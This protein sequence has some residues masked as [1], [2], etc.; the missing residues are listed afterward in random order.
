MNKIFTK[1]LLGIFTIFLFS[2]TS[3]AATSIKLEQPQTQTYKND[4]GLTFV[5]LDTNPS[6]LV[7]VQCQKKGP[8]DA[9]FVNFG[10]LIVLS[11]GGNTDV[12]QVNSGIVNQNEFIYQFRAIAN[13]STSNVLSNSVSVKF[14]DQ[15]PGAPEGY[16]KTMSDSCTYKISFKT[17]NDS[18]TVRVVLYRSTETIFTVDLGHQVNALN[19][20][21]NTE[22]SILDNITPN[23]NTTYYYVIRAYDTYGKG[24]DLRGDS[25]VTTTVVNPTATQVQGAILVTTSEEEVLGSTESAEPSISPEVINTNVPNWILTHKKI[26]LLGLIIIVCVYLFFNRK[27]HKKAKRKK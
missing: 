21:P 3:F 25:N 24:S 12:C 13:G 5:A 8:S 17:A 26:S 4:F 10:S 6:Q 1:I 23:C 11:S 14:N 18:K 16:S 15:A 2:G 9:D 27:P 22:G 20:G 19:I 7:T